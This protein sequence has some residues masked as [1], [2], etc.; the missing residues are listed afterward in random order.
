MTMTISNFRPDRPAARRGR[1][2]A[3]SGRSYWG[4]RW[5][6]RPRLT[7]R[8]WAMLWPMLAIFAFVFV[9]AI[10]PLLPRPVLIGCALLAGWV[11]LAA[12]RRLLA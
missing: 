10:N 9:G 6:P 1:T 12:L 7:W 8:S 11:G 5:V 4:P 2:R 3:G